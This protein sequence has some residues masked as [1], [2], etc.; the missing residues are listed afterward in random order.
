MYYSL[1]SHVVQV[2]LNDVCREESPR[3]NAGSAG[4]GAASSTK[5]KLHEQIESICVF[6]LYPLSDFFRRVSVPRYATMCSDV[7]H[8]QAPATVLKAKPAK[9]ADE[10]KVRQQLGPA[11][12]GCVSISQ[13]S[14]QNAVDP[15]GSNLDSNKTIFPQTVWPH[16]GFLQ[17]ESRPSV[18]SRWYKTCGV[19]C[20]DHYCIALIRFV[21]LNAC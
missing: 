20:W 18:H 13:E 16:L 4:S 6:N 3:G 21:I 17:S 8:A 5:P 7:P 2:N 10:P 15:T 12:R 14:F 19:S 1:K 11:D 9:L